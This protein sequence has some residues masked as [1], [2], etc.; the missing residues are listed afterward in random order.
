MRTSA[1]GLFQVDDTNHHHTSRRTIA[2]GGDATSQHQ[3]CDIPEELF[4]WTV[5]RVA[6]EFT[7][8]WISDNCPLAAPF[9]TSI[10]SQRFSSPCLSGQSTSH[11]HDGHCETMQS[12]PLFFILQRRTSG[13]SD[14]G[15]ATRHYR[16][17]GDSFAS[18]YHHRRQFRN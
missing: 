9:S 1:F 3:P 2:S 13:L 14:E 10:S 11:H 16:G 18:D 4:S 6:K 17:N 12:G 5:E 15:V 8:L 7:L